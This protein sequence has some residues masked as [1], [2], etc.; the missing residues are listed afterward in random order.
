MLRLCV[1][2]KRIVDCARA[3]VTVARLISVGCVRACAGKWVWRVVESYD[4]ILGKEFLNFEPCVRKLL[5]RQEKKAPRFS[6]SALI[7]PMLLP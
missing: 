2:H 7:F 1:A 3:V 4:V 6:L 5:G